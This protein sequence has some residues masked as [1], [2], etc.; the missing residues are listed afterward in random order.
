MISLGLKEVKIGA[1]LGAACGFA[2]D[3]VLRPSYFFPSMVLLGVGKIRDFTGC[4]SSSVARSV[5]T[6]PSESFT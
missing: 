6:Y 1:I 2:S 4:Y 3:L 5:C